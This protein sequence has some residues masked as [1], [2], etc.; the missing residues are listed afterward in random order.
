MND[1]MYFNKC[2]LIF[3][4]ILGSLIV[5][6]VLLIDMFLFGLLDIRYDF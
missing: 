3:I 1:L 5:I 2:L 6:G 4:I